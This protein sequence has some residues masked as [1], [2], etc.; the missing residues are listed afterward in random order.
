MV[1]KTMT[2]KGEPM[3]KISDKA[4]EAAHL[5]PVRQQAGPPTHLMQYAQEDAGKGVST[6]ASDNLVPLIYVLHPLS[7]QVDKR[8]NSYIEGAEGGDIW[9]RNAPPGMEIVKGEVGILVQPCYFY[10]DVVEWVPRLEGGGGGQ[11]FIGRHAVEDPK[12]V[13]GAIQQPDNVNHW[14]T[15]DGEHDLVETR[16][17]AVLVYIDGRVLPYLIPFTS[18][19]HGVS[20]AWMSKIND[21]IITEGDAKGKPY[22]SYAYLYRLTTEQRDNKKGKWFSFV[23]Q[24]ERWTTSEEYL[25]GRKLHA[26]FKSGEKQADTPVDAETTAGTAVDATI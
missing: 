4:Q 18:T 24:D 3:S 17:H 7:P 22:P 21:K 10:K 1:T 26:Q 9:L 2:R 8:S 23:P 20:R 25:V 16:N 5:P 6:K 12:N 14:T 19:G 11:G 13:P 15:A